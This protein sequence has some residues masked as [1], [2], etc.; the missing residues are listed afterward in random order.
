M[1]FT[2]RCIGFSDANG[3]GDLAVLQAIVNSDASYAGGCV[4]QYD[5]INGQVS[6][7]DDTGLNWLGPVLL[8]E[9]YRLYNSRCQIESAGEQLSSG[10]NFPLSIWLRFFTLF[11][12][13]KI[14][15]CKPATAAALSAV[16]NSAE[17][18]RL[19]R[20]IRPCPWLSIR[21]PAKA[22]GRPFAW[23]YSTR[24][25]MPTCREFIWT[26]KAMGIVGSTTIRSL[27]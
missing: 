17:H 2:I 22:T 19:C 25:D 6:L 3:N 4:V 21:V 27:S 14:F 8:A 5:R 7:A 9:S 1:R 10:P 20:I 16:C 24:T 18:S 12:G 13:P 26:S 15:T 11:E 23:I